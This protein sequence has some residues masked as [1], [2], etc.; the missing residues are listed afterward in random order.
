MH[1]LSEKIQALS[2]LFPLKKGYALVRDMDGN[3]VRD[4]SFLKPGD[5]LSLR[6]HKGETLA[7]VLGKD[8]QKKSDIP[9]QNT[10]NSRKNRKKQ[11]ENPEQEML[12]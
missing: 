2:P 4:A 8:G 9:A 10:N 3:A 7:E 6:F 5:R 1:I 11:P 12:W